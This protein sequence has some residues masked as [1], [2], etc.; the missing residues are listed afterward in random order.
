MGSLKIFWS[1]EINYFTQNTIINHRNPR[2]SRS[3]TKIKDQTIADKLDHFLQNFESFQL[4]FENFLMYTKIP[5]PNE[6]N[7]IKMFQLSVTISLNVRIDAEYVLNLRPRIIASDYNFINI[8]TEV[9]AYVKNIA[10]TI[11]II[12]F[13]HVPFHQYIFTRRRKTIM[14]L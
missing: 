12:N 2:N 6:T 8:K 14:L 9:Q 3:S 1:F 5:N 13:V 10:Q 4:N 7:S 11:F